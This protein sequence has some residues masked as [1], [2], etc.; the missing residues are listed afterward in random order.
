MP[1]SRPG[2]IARALVEPIINSAMMASEISMNSADFV[3][4]SSTP[5]MCPK[6]K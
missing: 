5:P 6:T 3:N 1:C 2:T 4:A